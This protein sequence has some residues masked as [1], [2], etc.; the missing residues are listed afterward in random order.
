M[1]ILLKLRERLLG[2]GR[3]S[4]YYATMGF[5][6]W[7]LWGMGISLSGVLL[8]LL[9]SLRL[10]S[11]RVRVQ[12]QID[13]YRMEARVRAVTVYALA[14]L[15]LA[16]GFFVA[17]VPLGESS[18]DGG[19]EPVSAPIVEAESVVDLED[20]AVALVATEPVEIV[21]PPA[22]EA[23]PSPTSVPLTPES[24][25]FGG[26]PPTDAPTDTPEPTDLPTDEPTSTP[27][28]TPSPTNT[29]TPLPT[30][31]PVPPPTD[32]TTPTPTLTPTPID[33]NTA[34][35]NTGGSTIWVSR[36]P[37]SATND[38]LLQDGDTVILLPGN[39]NYAGIQWKEIM[40]VTGIVG[41]VQAEFLSFSES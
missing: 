20:E 27:T 38:A 30:N 26:P 34:R 29:P 33:G 8:L 10:Q 7:T 22:S 25:A 40:T 39:A 18:E 19:S 4:L 17:G 23:T 6:Q 5:P 11:T 32:T 37:G 1:C 24:G 41:W 28:I 13:P 9:Y 16:G 35:I 3:K 15:L 36:Y 21:S 2:F 14:L 12:G 31:T